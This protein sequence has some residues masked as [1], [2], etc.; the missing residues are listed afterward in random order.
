MNKLSAFI[1]FILIILA[2]ATNSYAEETYVVTEVEFM[3]HGLDASHARMQ[4]LE[5]APRLAI[6]KIINEEKVDY[7]ITLNTPTVTEL[8]NI[9]QD[10]EIIEENIQRSDYKAFIK[11][12]F[13]QQQL[14]NLLG[15]TNNIKA[16]SN[17]DIVLGSVEIC[18]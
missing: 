10:I 15:I 16:S 7:K 3:V 9:V 6:D 14:H 8:D 2:Y 12:R 5:Q 1:Y 13:K 11:L 4:G 18:Y 17:K